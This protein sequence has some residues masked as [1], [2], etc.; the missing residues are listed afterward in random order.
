[1]PSSL[2]APAPVPNAGPAR[3]LLVSNGLDAAGRSATGIVVDVVAVVVLGAGALQMGVLGMLGTLGFLV[4]GIPVGVLVD[5]HL[6][7]RL[8]VAA[9]LVKGGLLGS[10]LVA[11]VLDALTFWHLAA[12]TGLVGV[13]GV[14]TETAQLALVPR[15]VA[16][17][18]VPRQIA[19]LESADSALGVIAPA[20]AGL[21]VSA[22]GAGPALA[23][24][25][26]CVA[27]AALAALRVRMGAPIP[28]ADADDDDP[29]PPTPGA[30]WRELFTEAGQGWRAVR[31]TPV[32]WWLSLGSMAA[33]T[34]M[35][36]FA[37]IEPLFVLDTLGLSP[38]FLGVVAGAGSAAALA[39]SLLVT[40]LT[41]RVGEGTAVLAAQAALVVSVALHV[42][43]FADQAR[44]AAW[45]LA[46]GVL[47]GVAIVVNNVS[48]QSLA[49]R[50]SA[51]AVLG[52]VMAF[53]RTLTM[54]VVPGAMLAGGALGAVAGPGA[55]LAAWLG[56][57]VVGAVLAAVAVRRRPA[58]EDS[59]ATQV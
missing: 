45:L 31:R 27:A 49:A 2:S 41:V 32:L 58:A 9:G 7:P 46:G 48:Q 17:G 18:A 12:A 1:M 38:L 19:R 40:P 4:F 11:L 56:L 13:A 29:P 50:I 24:A 25:V 15:T 6:S 59:E 33:N 10:V 47:W 52:R 3:W 16:S 55:V 5:R 23:V 54:G 8:L 21:L 14:V 36:A 35:S 44:A 53:R 26:A 42:V 28:A 43:A 20:G 39:G 22:A 34:G 51:P 37:A 30:A 57:A